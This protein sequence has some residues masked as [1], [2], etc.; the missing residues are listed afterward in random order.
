MAS[1]QALREILANFSFEADTEKLGQIDTK[2]SSLAGNIAAVAAVFGGAAIIRGTAIFLKGQA[3]IGAKLDDQSNRLGLNIDELQRFQYQAQLTGASGDE[4]AKGLGFLNKNVGLAVQGNKAATKTFAQLGVGLKNSDGSVRTLSEILPDVAEAFTKVGSEEEQAAFGQKIFGK[5]ATNLLPLLKQTPKLLADLSKE[6]DSL[7]GG[8]SKKFVANA[9]KADDSF[10][11]LNFAVKG[12]KAE[13]ATNLLPILDKVVDGLIHGAVKLRDYA[14]STNAVQTAFITLGIAMGAAIVKLGWTIANA[15]GGIIK[16]VGY[17]QSLEI[18]LTI[19]AIVAA[20][21]L[22][23]FVI[24]E[25]YTTFT[26]GESLITDWLDAFGGVGTAQKWVESITTAWKELGSAIT[27]SLPDGT[28]FAEIF[29]SA[30]SWTL[31]QLVHDIVKLTEFLT[32]AV[33]ELTKLINFV[34]HPLDTIGASGKL[35]DELDSMGLFK[36]LPGTE[37]AVNTFQ[38]DSVRN[39]AKRGAA[40]AGPTE[41]DSPGG[42]ATEVPYGPPRVWKPITVNNSHTVQVTVQGGD[43]PRGNGQAVANG[44]Q[45]ALDTANQDALNALLNNG[46]SVD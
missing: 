3:A 12:L 44:A 19:G 28:S 17:L 2:I 24:D 15:V 7:G 38:E 29:K 41:H 33:V 8:L 26:G 42:P 5:G 34:N 43:D 35:K 1:G 10:D 21:A 9:A 40:A 14:K 22:L 32:K 37:K 16:S 11:K 46:G 25:L 36:I 18:A 27:A 20:I 13:I 39:I 31:G 45:E 23:V 6:Y 30:A 4:A